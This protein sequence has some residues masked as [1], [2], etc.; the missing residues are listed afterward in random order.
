MTSHVCIVC[1]SWQNAYFGELFDAI[2][3]TLAEAGYTIER[4]WDRFPPCSSD[5]AF[6]FV[7]HEFYPLVGESAHPTDSQLRRSVVLCTEQPGTSWF[8]QSCAIAMRAARVVDINPLAARE[9][10]RRGL[11]VRDMQLGYVPAWDKWHEAPDHERPV[12]VTFMGGYTK[13][14]GAALAMCGSS[15]VR[16]NVNLRIF[17]TSRPRFA[18]S[19]AFLC[20]EG[21][22]TFLSR[23]KL[24]INV[25]RTDLPY[26][27]WVRIMEALMNGCVPV[28]EHSIGYPPLEPGVHFIS[29]GY[30]RLGPAVT[31]LLES[32]DTLAAIRREGYRFLRDELPLAR[33]ITPLVEAIEE[34]QANPTDASETI[35]VPTPPS[36]NPPP[37]PVSEYERIFNGRTEIDVIRAGIKDILLS[38]IDLRRHLS[39]LSKGQSAKQDLIESFGPG[40]DPVRV[41]VLLTVYNYA[42]FVGDAI[43]S[44][45]ESDFEEL[46]LIVVDDCSSDDSLSVVR[47]TLERFPGMRATIIARASNKG[48]GA[49]RNRAIEGA[50]GEY[51][52]VLDADNTIYPHAIRRLVSALDAKP[53]AKFA[54]SIIEQFGANGPCDIIGW[55]DW[56][57]HA[58]RY[59]N[60]IDAMA[61]IRRDALLEV[62]GYT[63]DRSLYGWE[64][65]DL[66]CAFAD[67]GWQGIH[68]PEILC[69][70]RVGGYSMISSTNID[71]QAA[72]GA[73]VQRHACLTAPLRASRPEVVDAAFAQGPRG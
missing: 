16:H 13:R 55:Q 11:K 39:A 31:A 40:H 42:E 15:L 38:Q 23:A 4:S 29:A 44:V 27:E 45:A 17:D 20:G 61:L 73:L 18:G 58:L 64:D 32:P 8:E 7:P 37:H 3:A 62:G 26:F 57:P 63:L 5:R 34:V 49:A 14:R 71:G 54:Y 28:S 12:D 25:H 35:S 9:L 10:R 30:T 66:W 68:V 56:N 72:W 1:A 21:K 53:G 51:V 2:E 70:Y 60:Y 22:W 24:L 67:R 47:Q 19:G 6:L 59:G 46:E 52:F 65:F 69:R 43:A 50:R 36:P 48:L 33:T 41:S